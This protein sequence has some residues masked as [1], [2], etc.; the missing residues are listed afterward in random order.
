MN[1]V[2]Q[3]EGFL[4]YI[5]KLL[6]QNPQLKITD[7]LMYDR[8]MN[9][10]LNNE[11][12]QK[13]NIKYLFSNWVNKYQSAK[14]LHV[15]E[16]NLQP[17]FLQFR[18]RSAIYSNVIKLYLS[19]PRDKMEQCVN[20]IF[21]FIEQNN[22]MSASK[23]SDSLRSDSVVLR[24][25]NKE[26]AN[27]V[28]NFINQNPILCQSAKSTNPFVMKA[29]ICGVGYDDMLSYNSCVSDI[30][31]QYFQKLKQENRLPSAS[32]QDFYQFVY[33]FYHNSFINCTSLAKFIQNSHF[34]QDIDRQDTVEQV[35]VNWK[36]IIELFINHLYSD[37]NMSKYYQLYDHFGNQISTNNLANQYHDIV[38]N[39]N[40]DLLKNGASNKRKIVED[41]IQYGM[42]KYGIEGI[43]KYL[44]YFKKT[45]SYDYITRDNNFR[46]RFIDCQITPKFIQA[47]VN[48]NETI[49][50]INAANMTAKANCETILNDYINYGIAAYGVDT[51]ITQLEQFVRTNNYNLITRQ[52]RLRDRFIEKNIKGNQID[53]IVNHKMR[54]YVQNINNTKNNYQIFL[55]SCTATYT[56]YG[57][58]QLVY[59]IK[60][61][62]NGDNNAFTNGGKN[63][64]EQLNRFL[65]KENIL[66]YCELLLFNLGY[67]ATIPTDISISVIVGGQM[68][69]YYA[70]QHQMREHKS[71]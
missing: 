53:E 6:E 5:S 9:Y 67:D 27:K 3:I 63:Y 56:K 41:Y 37:M 23:V 59:A 16:S 32:H 1:R 10:G 46:T 7:D 25:T 55:E 14:N 61:A 42:E 20:I 22:I 29:G 51:T 15:Y 33:E 65:S 45:G 26:E 69:Q 11:E 49:N 68:E 17:G 30:L 71:K 52:N 24:L 36:Q 4:K 39:I 35:I 28:I 60:Q 18:S 31:A 64:R 19:F 12:M 8:L 48:V 38:L 2:E 62:F 13:P 54:E 58:E 70:A 44:D 66:D 21:D 43:T 47:Q 40:P 50:A 34:Q 57:K